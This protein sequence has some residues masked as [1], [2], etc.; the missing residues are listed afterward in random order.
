MSRESVS[1]SPEDRATLAL[2][3][4]SS[5]EEILK[6][7]APALTG[8]GAHTTH[9]DALSMSEEVTGHTHICSSSPCSWSTKG[10]TGVSVLLSPKGTTGSQ[11]VA[12]C[13]G[14][15]G[16]VRMYMPTCH[17]LIAFQQ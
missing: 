6:R 8:H 17:L 12:S 3:V 16:G 9:C 7:V 2:P 5:A 15:M 13:G 1:T 10:P 14:G 11:G 4:P